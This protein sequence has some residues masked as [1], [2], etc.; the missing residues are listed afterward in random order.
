MVYL[1]QI[2]QLLITRSILR[3]DWRWCPWGYMECRRTRAG[4]RPLLTSP[5]AGASSRSD[6]RR[7]HRTE[8]YL[9]MG[10]KK[11][12]LIEQSSTLTIDVSI[13]V[14]VNEY[15]HGR[16]ASTWS[17]LSPRMSVRFLSISALFLLLTPND[18][19]IF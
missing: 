14:L 8:V 3:S 2:V 11:T 4:H 1:L 19:K 10:G 5:S 15:R 13:L 17:A 12:R 18:E 9:E 7:I 6:L 16:C